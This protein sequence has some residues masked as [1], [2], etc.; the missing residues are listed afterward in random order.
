[1]GEPAID[2][3]LHRAVR[4]VERVHLGEAADIWRQ[5]KIDRRHPEHLVVSFTAIACMSVSQ[6]QRQS[7]R[8]RQCDVGRQSGTR[9]ESVLGNLARASRQQGIQ[10]QRIHRMF[11]RRK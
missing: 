8:L 2:I 4:R 7:H 6:I 11:V 10:Q 9:L 5:H 3:F 1:M